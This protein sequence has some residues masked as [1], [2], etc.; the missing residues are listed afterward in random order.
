LPQAYLGVAFGFGIPMGFAAI[1]EQV[2]PIAVWMLAGNIFWAIAYDT[3]YAMVDRDDDLR[4][5]LKTSAITFGA[6]DV[7][8]VM[9]CY[10]MFFLI[11]IHVG[12]LAGLGVWYMLGLVAAMLMALYHNVLIRERTREGC[13]AAFMHNNWLGAAICAG[14]VLDYGLRLKSWPGF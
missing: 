11:M 8:A 9:L 3:E 7:G 5:G 6:F 12:N 13:F 1:L 14:I 2:P 4:L 10:T